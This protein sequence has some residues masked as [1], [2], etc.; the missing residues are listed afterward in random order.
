PPTVLSG[1][2]PVDTW[3]QWVFDIEA[4]R[5]GESRL[6]AE[7]L[8]SCG[9]CDGRFGPQW[10]P[11][12]RYVLFA[13]TVQDGRI[14]LADL[15]TGAS[16]VVAAGTDLHYRPSWSSDRER[17][18]FLARG[19]GDTAVLVDAE[20]G[21]RTTLPLGWPASFGATGTFAYSPS[22]TLRHYDSVVTTVVDLA[23]LEVDEV[24]GAAPLGYLWWGAIAV[25]ALPDDG[26]TAALEADEC[27]GTIVHSTGRPSRCLEGG[28]G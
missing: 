18:R 13:E 9:G 27:A 23:T 12:G 7:G 2:Y 8:V 6:L 28:Y 15:E 1:G 11:D 20:S 4:A 25:A 26:Y 10:S 22:A 19:E 24:S 3:D 21:E 17:A 14:F 16:E 5:A